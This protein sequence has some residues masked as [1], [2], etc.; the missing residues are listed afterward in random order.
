MRRHIGYGY[1]MLSP[2]WQLTAYIGERHHRF[3]KD[4]YPELANLHPPKGIY[5][6]MWEGIERLAKLLALADCY[7]AL[8]RDNNRN[9]LLNGVQIKEKMIQMW[10]EETD[11]LIALYEY[12]IFT[13][14]N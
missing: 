13:T 10:S 9:G 5:H 7:D 2:I 6:F 4:P 1:E 12:R 8:H 11:L 3:Q 14:E